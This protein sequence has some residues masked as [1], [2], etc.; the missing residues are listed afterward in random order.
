MLTHLISSDPRENVLAARQF[1]TVV[2]IAITGQCLW[3]DET[4]Q[5]LHH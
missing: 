2:I 5:M 1:D 4:W 3:T